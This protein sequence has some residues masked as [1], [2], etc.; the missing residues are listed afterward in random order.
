MKPASVPPRVA[1]NARIRV[2]VVTNAY[3]PRIGGITGY[4]AELV[5][6]LEG[7]QIPTHV[8]AMPEP[9]D[10][11]DEATM[12]RRGWWRTIHLVFV[13]CFVLT[14]LLRILSL[15][16]RDECM[17]V[18]SHSASYCLF[19]AVVA[20]L[21]GAVGVH[22]FH[23]PLMRNSSVL[24]FL[25]PKATGCVFVSVALKNLYADRGIAIA[26]SWIIPGAIDLTRFRPPSSGERQA[27]RAALAR[28]LPGVSDRWPVVL[29]VGRIVS[30]KGVDVL[31]AACDD[32]IGNTDGLGVVIAGPHETSSEGELFLQQCLARIHARRW[33]GRVVMTGPVAAEQLLQ[34]YWAADI[35]VC[36][37]RWPEPS[38][39]VVA[40]A[41]ACGLPV[42]ASRVGG[43][44]ERID[45]GVNGALVTPGDPQELA[46]GIL[47][48][49]GEQERRRNHVSA[50]RRSAEVGYGAE[51]MVERHLSL[52]RELLERSRE[53]ER[54]FQIPRNR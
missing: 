19:V 13:A 39:L 32:L 16:H 28:F 3:F 47:L 44:P 42:V 53:T 38:P 4:L 1:A 33:E 35:L 36:P 30:D 23:S 29:F 49:L 37:S 40:E 45:D 9:M 31:L 22:T 50:A 51:L 52:Y 6:G 20:K 25:V 48:I 10:R 46:R 15:R 27:A 14:T 26:E 41:L 11:L 18:H 34:L 54:G 7:H 2:V 17:I 24:R 12:G 21:M 8:F 5:R 43:L